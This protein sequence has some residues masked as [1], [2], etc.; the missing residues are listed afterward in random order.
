M[1]YL[2]NAAT[3]LIKPPRV[4]AAMQLAMKTMASPGRGAYPA[5]MAAS[6][7]VLACRNEAA[8]LFRIPAEQVVLTANATHALNIAVNSLVKRG[9]RVVVSGFEHN[10]VMRP[11][12][13]AGADITVAGR[14]LFDPEDTRKAFLAAIPYADAVFCTHV[15]NVF[16]YILPVYE[17]A[18]CCREYG[19][20]FVLDAS[21]SAGVLE[22]DASRLGARFVA[23]PGHK[24][25]FGPP[26]TGLLLCGGESIPL[27]YG[28]S[29]TDSR[30]KTMPSYLPDRLEAGTQNAWA[31]AGLTEGL[32]YVRARSVE[33]IGKKES[34]LLELLLR[35]MK[36]LPGITAYAGPREVQTG[37]L[38]LRFADKSCEEAAEALGRMGLCT[39][40]GLHC[41]PLAHES[42]GTL[43]RG[44]V[45]ISLSD[46][47]KETDIEA[48]LKMFKKIC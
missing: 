26:G 12:Y 40:A 27:L 21:Q 31:A 15:S 10:A 42:A 29:G 44:T 46:R 48:A 14:R 9:S 4:T 1:I 30:L 23:M 7:A 16:G 28:G 35:E 22:V 18:A 41:A 32:R 8:E 33:A 37:V 6:E 5:A 2:D 25:L 43:D 11:L 13:A 19:V 39:R 17:I 47:S 3:T 34:R 36:K 24:A 20:P 45:R 38:S